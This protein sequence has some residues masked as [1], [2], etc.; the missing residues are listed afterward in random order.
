MALDDAFMLRSLVP[1]FF[2]FPQNKWLNSSCSWFCI[3]LLS[4]GIPPSWSSVSLVGHIASR[5]ACASL[6]SDDIL[7][8]L[9]RCKSL[10][11]LGASCHFAATRCCSDV[12]CWVYFHYKLAVYA[13][14][15]KTLNSLLSWFLL[16]SGDAAVCANAV[17]QYF[18]AADFECR[19]LSFS[20]C[21]RISH[22]FNF[23]HLLV[24]SAPIND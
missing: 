3:I 11:A 23:I 13:L 12:L 1:G 7:V 17:E 19:I 9:R 2:W 15:W 5:L 22:F 6:M 16:D 20:R 18:E 8:T 21:V 24:S 10:T 14:P 4:F